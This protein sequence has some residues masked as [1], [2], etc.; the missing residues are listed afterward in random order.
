MSSYSEQLIRQS[1]G[2]VPI[3][4]TIINDAMTSIAEAVDKQ[5]LATSA[6]VTNAPDGLLRLLTAVNRST[7]TNGKAISADNI[8]DAIASSDEKNTSGLRPGFATNFKVTK[9]L[10]VMRPLTG[11]TDSNVIYQNG[12]ILGYPAGISNIMSS[13]ETKGTGTNLSTFIWSSDWQTAVV[14]VWGQMGM[15]VDPYSSAHQGTIRLIWNHYLDFKLART[16]P[17]YLLNDIITA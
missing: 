3:Q 16:E 17:W 12:Q 7:S 9:K 8:Y 15:L 1:G 11:S 14:C 2:G 13:G 5:I 4:Q 10:Q 6:S